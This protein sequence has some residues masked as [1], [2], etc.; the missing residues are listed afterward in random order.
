[1]TRPLRIEFENAWYHVINRGANR[2]AIFKS[3]SHRNLFY[4][5]LNE[6]VDRFKI[7][8][9]AFCLMSNH[10]HLLVKTPYANL[11][12]AMRHL[13]GVYTQRY[14]R[15]SRRDG[16]LFRG[17]YKA[18]L[19]D[20]DS[21]LLQVS[22]YIHLNPVAANICENAVGYRWSS[23]PSYENKKLSI[24]WLS[25]SFILNQASNINKRESYIAFV[26]QG[27]DN[28][29]K[30]FYSKKHLPSIYGEKKFIQTHLQT[31][32]KSYMDFVETDINHTKPLPEKEKIL[33]VVMNYFC[34]S[35]EELCESVKGKKN[36]PKLIAIYLL[37]QLCQCKHQNISEVFVSLKAISMSGKIARL[38]KL[39]KHD[40]T[41]LKCISDIVK[42]IER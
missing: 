13:N 8:I 14:N 22:R 9:H 35:L 40:K 15:T 7:E 17:R 36:I 41:M 30:R 42:Q 23:Y 5:I 39:M 27:V 4:T 24:S 28:E 31:L 33:S 21:Y 32:K 18:I 6:I 3:N 25:T 34:I 2:Q 37:S 10:Y 11:S 12:R 20:S 19:V 1:M 26:N 16:P 29:T 38:K